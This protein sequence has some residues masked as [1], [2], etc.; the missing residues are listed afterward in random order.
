MHASKPGLMA[1]AT[2]SD[3]YPNLTDAEIIEMARQAGLDP[4]NV[5]PL[6]RTAIL[7][8]IKGRRAGLLPVSD[9]STKDL[10]DS[11]TIPTVRIGPQARAVTRVNYLKILLFGLPPTEDTESKPPDGRTRAGRAAAKAAAKRRAAKPARKPAPRKPAPRKP[12]RR[13]TP[14]AAPPP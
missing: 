10:I 8:S 13:S 5:P 4:D 6:L 2:H 1:S 9:R 3:Y 14:P 7:G 12:E 11:G